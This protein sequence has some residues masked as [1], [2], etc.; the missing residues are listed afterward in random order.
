MS[1]TENYLFYAEQPNLVF[2]NFSLR[3]KKDFILVVK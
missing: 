3:A 2:I 1:F